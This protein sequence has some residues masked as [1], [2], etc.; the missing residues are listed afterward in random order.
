MNHKY[1]YQ[2]MHG[3][4]T[5]GIFKYMLWVHYLN[6][7]QGVL[8][9]KWQRLLRLRFFSNCSQVH[10]L[11]AVI[12]WPLKANSMA[13]IPGIC[14]MF[15][16]YK[17]IQKVW[18]RKKNQWC[19]G[20]NFFCNFLSTCPV[21]S[22]SKYGFSKMSFNNHQRKTQWLTQLSYVQEQQERTSYFQ[23]LNIIAITLTAKCCEAAC[24]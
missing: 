4:P 9:S 14:E 1:L 12:E 22:L 18:K 13:I 10:W 5:D 8:S 11:L 2:I 21:C 24:I 19:S 7:K 16:G 20:F 3:I 15:E 23:K 6:V 17:S